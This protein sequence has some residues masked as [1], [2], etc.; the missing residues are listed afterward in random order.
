[1]NT[2]GR[3][4]LYGAALVAAF[5][6]AFGT[7]AAVAPR[8]AAPGQAHGPTAGH[9][10]QQDEEDGMNGHDAHRSTTM[11]HSAHTAND[12][13]AG[14]A[15]AAGGY[16]LAPV[17]APATAG[18]AGT[19]SFRILDGSGTPVTAYEP[20]HEKELHLI[21][22][23]TDGARFRHV[24]PTLDRATGT[25]SIPW[26]WDAGGSYRVFTDFAA[27]GADP[28]T[29]ARTVDVAG[30]FA[31][32]APA[33]SATTRVDGFDA[34]IAGDLVPGSASELTVTISRDGAPVT[35][36]QPYLGAFGHLVAL[37]EGD[38]AYLHV[39]P[40]GAP[41]AEPGEAPAPG[42]TSG[43]DVRF[44]AHVPTA[45]RYLLYFDFQVDGS[46]HTAAFVLDAKAAH[47]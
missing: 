25:W 18:E 13:P 47:H 46:V 43:P 41:V 10:K 31:P 40:E 35:T 16:T 33:T 7:A 30:P 23:R 32:A 12:T 5:A 22:V 42:A 1:M 2:A 29:L 37:R 20:Q 27:R 39:H 4:G 11:D 15:L 3:L 45:G 34:G 6:V 24:H 44:A 9:E 36:L 19:L 21:V 38:L 14:V 8:G 26:T 28:V 17:S